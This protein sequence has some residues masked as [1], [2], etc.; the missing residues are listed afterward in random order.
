MRVSAYF[1]TIDSRQRPKS[2]TARRKVGNQK[3]TRNL[4]HLNKESAILSPIVASA[5]KSASTVTLDVS[6]IP[7]GI[8]IVSIQTGNSTYSR[9]I[10]KVK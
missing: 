5:G 8:Y 3:V 2:K 9:K 10:L 6:T 4:S 1:G 7:T